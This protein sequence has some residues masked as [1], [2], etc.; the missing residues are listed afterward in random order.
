LYEELGDKIWRR[1]GF[2]DAFNLSRGWVAESHLAID[3]GPIVVM[4][5]NARSGLLWKHFMSCPEIHVGL[6]R[7]GFSSSA[8]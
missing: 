7:L 2:V 6:D 8:K 1:F 5:E 4:I 3:Q